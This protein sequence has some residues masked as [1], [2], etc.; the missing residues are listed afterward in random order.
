MSNQQIAGYLQEQRDNALKSFQAVSDLHPHFQTCF[1]TLMNFDFITYRQ[2]LRDEILRNVTHWQAQEESG[3][4]VKLLDALLFEFNSIYE[5]SVDANAYGVVDWQDASVQIEG[6]DMGFHYDFR[7]KFEAVPG[8]S[9]SF[10]QPLED[11]LHPDVIIEI[12]EPEQNMED[13]LGFQHLADSYLF[14]GLVPVHEV[15]IELSQQNIFAAVGLKPAAQFLLGGHDTG[16]VYPLL[17]MP[18][19]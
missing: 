7:K 17:C 6:F 11:L 13:I 2:Q 3:E 9:L 8:I 14:S 16:M 5:W 12:A 4:A 18:P 10:L 15:L 19:N 1:A